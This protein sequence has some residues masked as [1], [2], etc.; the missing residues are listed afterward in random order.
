LIVLQSAMIG[1]V[2][3]EFVVLAEPLAAGQVGRAYAAGVCPVKVA[4]Y[5]PDQPDATAEIRDATGH[6]EAV[7]TGEAPTATDSCTRSW[8]AV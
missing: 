5:S 6:V 4:V 8:P 2:C 7:G 3:G 1:C